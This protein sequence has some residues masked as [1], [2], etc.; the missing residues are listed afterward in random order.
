MKASISAALV[1]A[2]GGCGGGEGATLDAQVSVDA[3][4][5]GDP[6]LG[7]GVVEL[8]QGGFQFTEGPQ[9]RDTE[10]DLLFSDV[11]GNT[12]FRYAPGGGAA[13]VFRM[14]SANANGLALDP[15]GKVLAAE[16]G[17]RSIT[18]AA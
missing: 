14:P 18:R 12:T 3:A 8:V 6:L 16:H 13:T 1:L 10:A 17:S 2:L 9:W 15:A 7:V 4:A 5:F 11:A